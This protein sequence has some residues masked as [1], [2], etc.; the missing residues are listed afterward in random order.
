MSFQKHLILVAAG[1]GSR[2]QSD[3]P[4]QFLELKGKAILVHALEKFLSYDSNMKVVVSVHTDYKQR[5][6]ELLTYHFK[7]TEITVCSGGAT[8]FASV[9]NGLQHISGDGVIAIHDAARPFVNQ[10]TIDTC[11]QAAYLHKAA[12]PVVP[13]HESIRRFDEKGNYAVDRVAFRIVQTP[14][15]FEANILRKA[16]TLP[17]RET[18]T[19][20]ASVVEASGCSIVF[21]EGN[22]ENIKITTPIDFKIAQCLIL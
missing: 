15:C 10:F 11:F 19:D 18:F 9:Q 3:I 6:S 20:D 14:Q 22:P 5:L 2:M 17:Y 16:Y 21:T 8:R 1:S 13:I 4:K 7:N 12:I